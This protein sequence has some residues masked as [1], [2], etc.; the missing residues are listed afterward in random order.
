[1][2]SNK[3]IK[4]R[5]E[6]NKLRGDNKFVKVMT[7]LGRI[8]NLPGEEMVNHIIPRGQAFTRKVNK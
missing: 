4:A 3:K 2:A 8:L 5:Q 6:E 7:D 1:M